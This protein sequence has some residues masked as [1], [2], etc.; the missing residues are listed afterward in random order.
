MISA[1]RIKAG[2]QAGGLHLG[3]SACVALAAAVL[4]LRIWFPYPFRDISGGLFLFWLMVGIDVVCGPL[5]TSILFN[6]KKSR[7]E[8]T[9]DLSLVALVQLSAL[10][11]GLYSISLARPIAQV[12]EVDRLVAV[13]AA[14]ITPADLA[15]ARSECRNISLFGGPLLLGTRIP[16]G[17][18]TFG[19]VKMALAGW[20]L[21]LRPEWWQPYEDGIADVKRRMKP[22]ADLRASRTQE[23]IDAAVQDTGLPLDQLFYLPLTSRK[24][25]D[26]WIAILNKDAQIV[27]YAPVDGF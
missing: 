3:I 7:R 11:Y 4:V 5:L 25:L 8:L 20:D 21:S 27:G 17:Q 24:K 15:K 13:T 10:V 18:E 2:L 26:S 16:N 1:E 22:L 9:L 23:P 6:P 14:Q 12:F 19:S